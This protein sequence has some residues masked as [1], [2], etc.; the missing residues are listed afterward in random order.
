MSSNIINICGVTIKI[1]DYN[2]KSLL[3]AA[4]NKLK[5]FL[6]NENEQFVKFVKEKV[7]NKKDEATPEEEAVMRGVTSEA[8]QPFV[9]I[10]IEKSETLISGAGFVIVFERGAYIYYAAEDE[11][12]LLLKEAVIMHEIGHIFLHLNNLLSIGSEDET[13]AHEFARQVLNEFADK[14]PTEY[15]YTFNKIDEVIAK[16]VE[17]NK[18]A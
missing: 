8:F 18:V 10:R 3:E 16:M 9:G 6:D 11:K 14:N 5:V 12:N 17:A 1:D 13:N 4:E 7:D 2:L 15:P